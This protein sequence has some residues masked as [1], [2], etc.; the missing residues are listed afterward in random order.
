M[1]FVLSIMCPCFLKCCSIT[2]MERCSFHTEILFHFVVLCSFIN[3]SR[4]L[5]TPELY[6]SAQKNEKYWK[7]C[8]YFSISDPYLPHARQL[9][10]F[11][12]VICVCRRCTYCIMYNRKTLSRASD[13]ALHPACHPA[14]NKLFLYCHTNVLYNE[15]LSIQ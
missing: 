7:S 1:T 9:T 3:I 6:E 11:W 14:D 4:Y 10:F 13:V 8:F 2:D 12:Q 5:P 15:P